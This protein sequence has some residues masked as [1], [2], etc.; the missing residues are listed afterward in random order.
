MP[1]SIPAAVF[2]MPLSTE[3]MTVTACEYESPE[4]FLAHPVSLNVAVLPAGMVF[5]VVSEE[6]EGDDTSVT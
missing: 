6:H 2:F 3:Y 4:S 5:C 1:V